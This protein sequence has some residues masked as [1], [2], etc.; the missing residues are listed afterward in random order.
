LA[1][2]Q[3]S[4]SPLYGSLQHHL[5]GKLFAADADVKQA[6][7]SWL[8]TIDARLN[9]SGKYVMVSCALPAAYIAG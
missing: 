6:V 4:D 5:A 9:V 7:T 8:R 2:E 3:P 1:V